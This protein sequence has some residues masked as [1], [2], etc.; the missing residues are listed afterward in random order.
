MDVFE[1]WDVDSNVKIWSC[2]VSSTI[3]YPKIEAVNDSLST[4]SICSSDLRRPVSPPGQPLVAELAN[5][6]APER[7]QHEL[8]GS[9]HHPQSYTAKDSGQ[10]SP[11]ELSGRPW[12]AEL[13]GDGTAHKLDAGS[14]PL[15]VAAKQSP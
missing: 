15:V 11:H 1:G 4:H 13:K 14:L 3:T 2:R 9:E 7:R 10:A 5:S 6:L 12:A 8:A